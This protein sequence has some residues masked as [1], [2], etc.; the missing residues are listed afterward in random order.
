[1]SASFSRQKM[2]RLLCT[3]ITF[4]C[5]VKLPIDEN[6]KYLTRPVPHCSFE[7][8]FGISCGKTNDIIVMNCDKL[9][10]E[11]NKKHITCGVKIWYKLIEKSLSKIEKLKIPSVQTLNDGLHLY[12]KYDDNFEHEIKHLNYAFKTISNIKINILSTR[13]PYIPNSKENY[14]SFKYIDNKFSI[15]FRYIFFFLCCYCCK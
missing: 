15:R 8:Y 4:P 12:F 11:E 5:K 10:P 1:M 2:D 13:Y 9:R 6:W 7:E 14:I 3:F